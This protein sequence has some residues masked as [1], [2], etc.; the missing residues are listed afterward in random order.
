MLYTDSE[1]LTRIIEYYRAR[2]PQLDD[3]TPGEVMLGLAEGDRDVAADLLY[4]AEKQLN[5]CMIDTA[6]GDDLD[7]L[8][9]GYG[10]SR[11]A[12]AK[13]HGV[14]TIS[15]PSLSSDTI[16]GTTITIPKGTKLGL[17]S[18][19]YTSNVVFETDYDVDYTYGDT[20]TTDVDITAVEPGSRGNVNANTITRILN[21]E[22]WAV[23][24]T[25]PSPTSGGHDDWSDS[26]YR[27]LFRAWLASM[28]K[29]TKTAVE[30][31]ALLVPGVYNA[32][33]AENVT[34]NEETVTE[35]KGNNVLF[36]WNGTDQTA[37][38]ALEIR[39]R[40]VLVD[41]YRGIGTTLTVKHATPVAV[42]L[43]IERLTIKQGYSNNKIK[44]DVSVALQRYIRSLAPS[45]NVSK[46]K[47]VQHAMQV[48]GVKE[49]QFNDSE[50]I[51]E[52]NIGCVA[53]PGDVTFTNIDRAGGESS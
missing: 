29:T 24:V 2:C 21:N 10:F 37:D 14:V 17:G 28:G 43:T 38:E 23:K 45:Q 6:K 7:V 22:S 42:D 4:Q 12:P 26:E 25:N 31:R 41:D 46:A 33:L 20:S 11:P 51:E 49:I 40:E 39:V 13:A 53:L 1:L 15:T 18:F 52:I 36:I 50:A 30:G 9:T 48:P 3:Y 8:L 16:V 19:N 35:L 34:S 44:N 47:A 27:R 5:R 32:Q